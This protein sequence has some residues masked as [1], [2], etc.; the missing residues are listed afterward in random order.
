MYYLPA[1]KSTQYRQLIAT[2][3]AITRA[4]QQSAYI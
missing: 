3:P 2:C 1:Y 4:N